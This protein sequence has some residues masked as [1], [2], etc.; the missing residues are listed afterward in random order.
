[1]PT[2]DKEP[3]VLDATPIVGVAVNAGPEPARTLPAAPVIVILPVAVVIASGEL[4]VTAGVPLEV[5]AVHVGVLAVACVVI[6]SAPLVPPSRINSPWTDVDCPSVSA[7][8]LRFA[9]RLPTTTF[10][11]VEY[12]A[13]CPAVLATTVPEPVIVLQP[14]ACVV[15][16]YVNACCVK[17]QLVSGT[18]PGAAVLPE[19]FPRRLSAEIVASESVPV[20]VNGLCVLASPVP[21]TIE[22]TVPV[23]V[24][25][26]QPKPVLVVHVS[27]EVALLHDG[28][29]SAVGIALDPVPFPKTVLAVIAGKS[30]RRSDLN[31]GVP[32]DPSGE[33][34][35]K[36]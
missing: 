27:A 22:V 16:L 15:V 13:I 32:L 4:A 21:I 33:A 14:K 20:V 11:E 35:T 7:P 12:H 25:L 6:V 36:F 19:A 1:V 10:V 34:K 17:E 3:V 31:V 29:V 2:K 8:L 23:P 9:F 24:M 26:L 5:P 30:S 28:I 18:A